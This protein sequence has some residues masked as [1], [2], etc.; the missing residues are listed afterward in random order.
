MRTGQ[1]TSF[2]G[3]GSAFPNTRWTAILSAG[4]SRDPAYRD[5]LEYLIKLYWKPVYRYVRVGWSKSNEDA[6]DL[7]QDFFMS[8]LA[9]DSLKE[10]GPDKGRFRSFLKAA[11]KN[12]L[13]QNKRDSARQ[14]RGGG[15]KMIALDWAEL[16]PGDPQ[17]ETP[18]EA[19][20]REWANSVLESALARL[21]ERLKNDGKTVYF[22]LF[23]KF[24]FGD[25]E[26]LSYE[27]LAAEFGLSKFDVGNYL[28]AARARFREVALDL[29]GEYVADDDR[30][31]DEEFG[32]LF[33]GML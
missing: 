14:K 23:R 29:I 11:L 28:K 25:G 24:Y 31:R 19:F 26:Q 21:G 20:D 15:A 22:E 1:D 32:D 18:D 27:Q 2:G 10:V 16:D 7:T 33:G 13:L 6:K 9:R 8:L 5:N 30:E 3:A 4:D 12:F 17:A